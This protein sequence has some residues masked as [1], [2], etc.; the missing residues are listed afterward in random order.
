[1]ELRQFQS[2][3]RCPIGEHWQKLYLDLGHSSKLSSFYTG[4]LLQSPIHVWFRVPI[5]MPPVLSPASLCWDCT[6]INPNTI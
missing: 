3:P 6:A 4:K 1:M 2:L 5:Y